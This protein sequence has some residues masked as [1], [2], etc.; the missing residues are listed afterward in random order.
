MNKNVCAYKCELIAVGA[1]LW[2]CD[3]VLILLIEP[4]YGLHTVAKHQSIDLIIAIAVATIIKGPATH[5][6]KFLGRRPPDHVVFKLTR[7]HY[8]L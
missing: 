6:P 2:L 7:L 4:L 8:A 1:M 3:T 5:L